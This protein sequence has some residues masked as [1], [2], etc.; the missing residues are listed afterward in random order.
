MSFLVIDVCLHVTQWMH[1]SAS[2][3]LAPLRLTYAGV[4]APRDWGVDVVRAL[5][6]RGP[7][8]AALV[9]ARPFGG[10]AAA[11][12]SAPSVVGEAM[13]LPSPGLLATAG[14]P[15]A[16]LRPVA[17]VASSRQWWWPNHC[18]RTPPIIALP[19]GSARL[20]GRCRRRVY[21]AAPGARFWSSLPSWHGKK[22][23]HCVAVPKNT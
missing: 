17:P 10:L 22:K 9:C 12:V 3:R 1:V 20:D 8:S 19:P 2:R 23:Q 5:G 14:A 7:G 6:R 4:L 11:A 15:L 16:A 13:A 18:W 21:G